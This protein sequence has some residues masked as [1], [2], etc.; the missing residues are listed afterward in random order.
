MNNTVLTINSH[1][2][3]PIVTLTKGDKNSISIS[4]ISMPENAFEFY[5]SLLSQI[6][7]FFG[8][9]SNMEL[10]FKMEYMN[11]MS[12]KQLLKLIVNCYELDNNLSVLW[13]YANDDELIKMKG[14]EMQA[15]YPNINI[16]I[17]EY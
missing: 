2:D 8:K 15:I 5:D 9:L 16:K 12:N 4:G 10:T 3:T 11:S 14:E 6:T 13:K 7:T 17:E 1:E